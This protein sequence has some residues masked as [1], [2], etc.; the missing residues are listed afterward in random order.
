MIDR[1][2]GPRSPKIDEKRGRIDLMISV[3]MTQTA[4]QSRRS[5]STQYPV[6]ADEVARVIASL[7]M[8][9]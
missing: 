3:P 6:T 9:K 7:P 5:R 1:L 2:R 4:Q 8:K